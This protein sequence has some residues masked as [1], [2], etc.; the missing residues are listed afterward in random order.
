LRN[1]LRKREKA[2]AGAKAETEEC[3]LEEA[4]IA[5][6]GQWPPPYMSKA[7]ALDLGIVAA[8]GVAVE[9]S[10]A[11]IDAVFTAEVA[12][13]AEALDLDQ[14]RARLPE[15]ALPH[16]DT[17]EQHAQALP[18]QEQAERSVALITAERASR[19]RPSSAWSVAV[20][21]A[22]NL[23]ALATT[24][25]SIAAACAVYGERLQGLDLRPPS[26]C[27]RR[28]SIEPES[29]QCH[30]EVAGPLSQASRCLREGRSHQP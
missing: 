19:A 16:L 30:L 17:A 1:P 4:F 9:R 25:I 12:I 21:W 24:A 29:N 28:H 11:A 6:C 20:R 2:A 27:R 14:L 22:T 23:P 13:G 15:F 10:Q 18:D 7:D 26:E 8:T 5:L 3:E